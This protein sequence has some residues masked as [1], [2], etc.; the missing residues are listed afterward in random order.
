VTR[1]AAHTTNQQENMTNALVAHLLN[2]SSVASLHALDAISHGFAYEA[3][4]RSSLADQP[5]PAAALCAKCS[6]P[7]K[8]AN[9]IRF[10]PGPPSRRVN[11]TSHVAVKCAA[12]ASTRALAIPGLSRKKKR[13][14]RHPAASDPPASTRVAPK[15]AEAL[16]LPCEKPLTLIE[17]AE[18]R[19]A[20]AKQ[21]KQATKR[22]KPAESGISTLTGL[23]GALRKGA[24]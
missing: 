4:R 18:L 6:A 15:R 9:P 11:A 17:Q 21:A 20:Q 2:L 13:A 23:V 3:A 16:P 8:P 12:C 5:L 1:D 19:A 24:T 22:A 7:L 14:R 10:K